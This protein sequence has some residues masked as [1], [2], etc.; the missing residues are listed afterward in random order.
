MQ[1]FMKHTKPVHLDF[2]SPGSIN[3]VTPRLLNKF[4]PW[5]TGTARAIPAPEHLHL[6]DKLPPERKKFT[7]PI[8]PCTDFMYAW[9]AGGPPEHKYERKFTDLKFIAGKTIA[10]PGIFTFDPDIKS[11]EDFIGKRIGVVRRESSNWIWTYALLKD[12]WDIYD[13]V[14]LS[15][16]QN[17][18]EGIDK[19][20][21]GET[22]ATMWGFFLRETINSNGF[23]STPGLDVLEGKK[24]HW[25]N[26]S[27]EDVEKINKANPWQLGRLIMPKGSIR[28]EGPKALDPEN[29][30]GVAGFCLGLCGWDDTDDNVVYELVKFLDE[31]SALWTEFSCGRPFSLG[32]ISRYPGLTEDMVHPA[33]LEYYKEKGISIGTQVNLRRMF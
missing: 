26:V 12:A 16:C 29:D 18:K 6:I 31:N 23:Y 30:T 7:L 27:L 13:K 2:I 19:I 9:Q 14:T 33:A 10:S 1:K 3:I 20:L 15:Y 5:I 22:D 11:P 17:P 25:I 8:M 4:H 24:I 32:R 28:A 21:K